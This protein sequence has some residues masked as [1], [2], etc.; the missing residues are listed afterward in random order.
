[1][2]RPAAGGYAA[3]QLALEQPQRPLD[4]AGAAQ[5]D[6]PQLPVRADVAVR[7]GI[8]RAPH[9]GEV[10][11]QARDR[12]VAHLRLIDVLHLSHRALGGTD[13]GGERPAGGAVREP[14]HRHDSPPTRRM[15]DASRQ[16]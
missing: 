1:M 14:V 9:G 5:A 10:R 15:P 4:L 8:D 7:V 11:A 2:I 16:C 6:G 3:G 12:P 13:T